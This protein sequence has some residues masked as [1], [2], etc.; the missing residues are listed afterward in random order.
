MSAKVFIPIS[1]HCVVF[2]CVFNHFYLHSS[3]TYLPFLTFLEHTQTFL[4]LHTFP[5]YV[6]Y[7]CITS[8]LH[9]VHCT[10]LACIF[11][12][13]CT[14]KERI[15]IV[16]SVFC[17]IIC[18]FVLTFVRI[19][20]ALELLI[21]W[22]RDVIVDTWILIYMNKIVISRGL[23][24]DKCIGLLGQKF[25]V[26]SYLRKDRQYYDKQCKYHEQIEDYYIHK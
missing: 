21:F 17:F 2:L 26:W 24:A 12:I 10:L 9:F 25:A 13:W 22:W 11:E 16:Q 19:A 7:A 6:S 8:L 18:H 3:L 20:H 23:P 1:L 5:F 14:H 4:R 15:V